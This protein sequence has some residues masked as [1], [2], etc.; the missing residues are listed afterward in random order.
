[1]SK[2]SSFGDL[3]EFDAR[4]KLADALGRSFPFWRENNMEPVVL[5][6]E[7]L[8]RPGFSGVVESIYR[9]FADSRGK[10]RWGD[11]SP[12]YLQHIGLLARYFPEARFI[13][14]YRDGR[15]VA[16]SFH[17]RWRKGPQR[18]I[19]RW[20]KIIQKGRVQAMELRP[21]RYMEVSYEAVT[22]APE[23]HMRLICDFLDLEFDSSVLKSSMGQMDPK[24]K[25]D[26]IIENREKWK[27]YFS[28]KLLRD[29]EL[30]AGSYLNDLGYETVNVPGDLNP[31]KAR[32]LF[33]T[34]KD[35]LQYVRYQVQS[36]GVARAP[37]YFRKMLSS[38]IQNRT[39]YY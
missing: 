4:R 15:D 31:S 20:K 23:V 1:M 13:H 5:K 18:T 27:G 24:I 9:Y 3:S 6:N 36:Y 21:S 17:R 10:T 22:A 34:C 32:L 29:L 2:A 16:Q 28:N 35:H 30:I 38:I 11:K 12:M 37:I 7:A 25:V 8:N 14:I 33:W 19:Y 39:N 26:R